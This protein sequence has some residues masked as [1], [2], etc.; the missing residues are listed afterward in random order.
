METQLFLHPFQLQ[1]VQ[2]RLVAEGG[3]GAWVE[4]GVCVVEGVVFSIRKLSVSRLFETSRWTA[5]VAKHVT[6]RP[7]LFS[8]FRNRL[9]VSGPK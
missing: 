1:T 2:E 8:V 7:Y 6:S 9:T 4:E 3:L 5:L